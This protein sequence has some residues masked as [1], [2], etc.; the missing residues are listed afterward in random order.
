MHK[1]TRISSHLRAASVRAFSLTA[2]RVWSPSSACKFGR[3]VEKLG[4]LRLML[5]HC[6]DSLGPGLLV[7]GRRTVGMLVLLPRDTCA[8]ACA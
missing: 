5:G 4:K 1:Q 2:L 8:R 6:V 7:L 3:L